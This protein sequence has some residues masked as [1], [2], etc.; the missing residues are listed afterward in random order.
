MV[1]GQ[2][3]LAA[4][5]DTLTGPGHWLCPQQE[6]TIWSGSWVKRQIQGMTGGVW[7]CSRVPGWP[8]KGL[9]STLPS[10]PHGWRTDGGG[11]A[12]SILGNTFQKP[13]QSST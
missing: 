5:R 10:L 11:E 4:V 8:A 13:G 12:D 3:T 7:R 6:L 9:R 2:Y 1:R